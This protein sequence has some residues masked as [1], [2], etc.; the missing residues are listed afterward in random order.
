MKKAVLFFAFA[1]FLI[2]VKAQEFY[3]NPMVS[4]GRIDTASARLVRNLTYEMVYK[5]NQSLEKFLTFG[6]ISTGTQE[7]KQRFV[8]FIYNGNRYSIYHQWDT[9]DAISLMNYEFLSIFVRPEGTTDPEHLI[10]FKDYHLNGTWD[11]YSNGCYISLA[12][13]EQG[14]L[15][16][17]Q[18]Q[19]KFIR[20]IKDALA[21]FNR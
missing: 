17:A 13:Y 11:E 20:V 15:S 21:F 10:S 3:I 16:D 18:T 19:A 2:T 4:V 5:M 8:V 1:L 6:E 14:E 7:L 9:S 12:E